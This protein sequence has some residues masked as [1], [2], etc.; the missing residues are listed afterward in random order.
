LPGGHGA[1]V[2]TENYGNQ[3]YPKKRRFWALEKAGTVKFT[4]EGIK[5]KPDTRLT[6]TGFKAL[7]K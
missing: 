3:M 2:F 4:L 6:I 5:F 1:I 7:L